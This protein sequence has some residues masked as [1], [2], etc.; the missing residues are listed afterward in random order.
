MTE[1]SQFCGH[2]F[3]TVACAFLPVSHDG[4]ARIITASKDCTIRVWDQHT[5]TCLIRH[6]DSTAGSI[7]GLAVLPAPVA[8]AQPVGGGAFASNVRIA[9]TTITAGVYV[10]ALDER[11]MKLDCVAK[12]ES[13]GSV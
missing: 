13:A 11:S 6:Q 9:V 5:G 10:Y 1:L 3:D 4:R 12:C 8:D 2:E 7:S